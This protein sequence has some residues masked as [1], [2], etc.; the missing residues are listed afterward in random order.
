MR[1]RPNPVEALN[2][3]PRVGD[4]DERRASWRQAVAALGRAQRIDG[5]PPLDGIEVS[6]L[7]SAARVA[8]DRGLADDLDWIAPSSRAVALYEISAALPPGNERREFGR[9][10]FTH[11]YGGTASTFAAVAH[12]MALGNAKPLDTATLRARVS[13]VTDLSIGA[14]VNSIPWPSPWSPAVSCSIAGWLSPP[15]ER[16]LRGVSRRGCS[17]ARRVR[18]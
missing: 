8:L 4:A 18:R 5:P 7:V 17:S 14:S 11:L 3:L 15:A 10:A 13:L 12:R 9:R 6:E 16:S 1:L 2:T